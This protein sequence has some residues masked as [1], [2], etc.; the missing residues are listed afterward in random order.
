MTRKLISISLSMLMVLCLFTTCFADSVLSS[1]SSSQDVLATTEIFEEMYEITFPDHFDIQ[2]NGYMGQITIASIIAEG[3]CLTVYTESDN[4]DETESTWVAKNGSHGLPYT[5]Y[6]EGSRTNIAPE[7]WA[8]RIF[9]EASNTSFKLKSTYNMNDVHYPG[10]YTDTLTFR[11]TVT[12][13][14]LN[15]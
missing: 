14:P 10:A 3:K 9:P 1:P 6:S 15:N 2:K 11:V 13:Y 8:I 7:I 12:D 4:Y 5:I